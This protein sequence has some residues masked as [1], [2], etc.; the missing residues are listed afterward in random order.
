MSDVRQGYVYSPSSAIRKVKGDE[1]LKRLMVDQ[2]P[3]FI[4]D[5]RQAVE[6]IVRG[7]FPL[8]FGIHPIILK[9][10]QT[11]GQGTSVKNLDF[12]DFPGT[13]GGDV[14]LLFNRAPHPNAAKLFINWLL[15]KEGQTAWATNVR[16]NSA[17]T[18]I[19]IVDETSAPKPG[20]TYPDPTQEEFI[21]FVGET[22]KFLLDLVGA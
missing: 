21:P 3:E 8:A 18:D 13:A 15:T 17:R 16:R 9:D 1:W 22:Q 7:R 11:E 5:R 19:P 2:Q 14:V 6:A 4:R 10:F 20:I 12:T